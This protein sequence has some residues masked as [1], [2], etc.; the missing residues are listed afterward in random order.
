MPITIRAARPED[1]DVLTALNAD[2]QAL[3][4]AHK[5]TFFRPP[6]ASAVSVWFRER[7]S[8][9]GARAWI[10]ELDGR[11]VGYALV[12]VR[13][14]PDTP[15]SVASR[16]YEI[17]QLGVDPTVR[18][19]GVA[20]ALVEHVLRDARNAGLREVTLRS[21]TFNKTAQRAFQRMGFTPEVVQMVARC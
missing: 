17:D 8:Q 6:D 20:R 3:H 5:P 13:E 11:D 9:P 14:R 15:F 10:A 1:A 2:V 19:R 21:W 18:R 16:T 12:V 4:A 7:L